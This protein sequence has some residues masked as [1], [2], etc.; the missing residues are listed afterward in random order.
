MKII[1]ADEKAE[2]KRPFGRTTKSLLEYFLPKKAKSIALYLSYLP[3][4]KFDDH[5]HPNCF[6]IIVFPK[7][8]KIEVNNS[9]YEL[10]EWD[11][12]VLEPGDIHGYSKDDCKDIIHFA[13]RL[14]AV[15]DKVNV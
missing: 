15:K 7:G 11:L 14:P 5:Y 8:G 3:T 10:S 12:V 4:G 1:R 2:E 9:P 6:E 13:I